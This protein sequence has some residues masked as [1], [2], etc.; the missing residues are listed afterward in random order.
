MSSSSNNS[1]NRTAQKL[2]VVEAGEQQQSSS[3]S[4]VRAAA[5]QQ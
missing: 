1:G 3:R 2:H 4:D 5:N